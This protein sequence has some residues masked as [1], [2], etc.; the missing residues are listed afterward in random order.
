VLFH[1]CIVPGDFCNNTML[2]ET[3]NEVLIAA[4]ISVAG[5]SEYSVY[6]WTIN[7]LIF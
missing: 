5:L 3:T 2:Q 4:Q 6:D 7:W 1:Q